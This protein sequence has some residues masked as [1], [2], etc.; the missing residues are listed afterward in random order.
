MFHTIPKPIQ[1]RMTYLANADEQERADNI[2]RFERLRQIPPETG[3]FLALWAASVPAGE[4]LEIGTSGDYSALWLSLAARHT[5]NKLTT[6]ELAKAKIALARE[7][8]KLTGVEDV[9]DLVEGD[10]LTHLPNYTDVVFCFLDTEKELYPPCYEIVVENLVSGGVLIVDN[11]ISHA[12]EFQD[13][14]DH[15]LSD[16]RVDALIVPIG[17]GLLVCRKL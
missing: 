1:D 2:P 11:V 6:F 8:F 14:I 15:A 4:W 3:K 12:H 13:M 9:I 7:T 16:N 17:K 10:V 5:Q